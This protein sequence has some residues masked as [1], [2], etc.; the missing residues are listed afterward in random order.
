MLF[1]RQRSYAQEVRDQA[2]E[3]R[4]AG[5]S[6][7][8]IIAQMGGD[9]PQATLQGWVADIEL[10]IEQRE[11]IKQRELAGAARGQRLGAQWN[12]EQKLERLQIA[13]TQAMPAV[14]R[15]AQDRDALM[16][17]ASALYLGE[18]AKRDDHLALG[19]SDPTIIRA[20]MELLRRCFEI[21]ESKFACQLSISQGMPDQALKEFWSQVTGI[22]L[23][24][25][26]KSSVKSHAGSIQR[27]GYKGV[28][29]VRYYSAEIRRYL[30]ALGRGVIATLLEIE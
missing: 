11:R 25:F 14:K 19:N 12:H 2:R 10:T 5:F 30:D 7:G 9:I 4:R 18:G 15:L 29:L 16:L 23:R 13:Q 17:M 27:E 1:R 28:C 22:P 3:L 24:Q 20:W 6:Y 26:H 21:D 8:E